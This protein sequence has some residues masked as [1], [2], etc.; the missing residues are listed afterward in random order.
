MSV[1]RFEEAP[2]LP[3]VF[4]RDG[5]GVALHAEAPGD[6]SHLKG[7]RMRLRD[8]LMRAGPLALAD[9]E[10]LELVMFRAVPQGDLNR[11]AKELLA[12]FGDF[13]HVIAAPPERLAE[14]TGVGEATIREFKIVEAAAHRFAQAQ[15]IGREVLGSWDRV[16]DYCTT[17]MAHLGTEQ[18]R[19]LFLDR[20]NV[21]I[22]DEAQQK[23]TVDHVPVYPRE[24][25]KRALQ[26]DASALILVHNHPSGDPAP[27]EADITMTHR[28][29]DAAQAIGIVLHDHI[30]IGKGKVASFR[31]L[32]LL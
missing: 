26:L 11:V 32:G 10:M 23:G 1:N 18:F 3:L 19:I 20:K 24:V 29:A 28:V 30:V 25:A 13:A 27:S 22:A 6:R 17:A 16:V 21:L 12:T 9:Y 15:V 7:H 4:E 2:P 14:V 31:S 5:S 8:R